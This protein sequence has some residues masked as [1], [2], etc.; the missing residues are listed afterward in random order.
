V[1]EWLK[2]GTKDAERRRGISFILI[3]DKDPGVDRR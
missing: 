3:V 1:E 2:N